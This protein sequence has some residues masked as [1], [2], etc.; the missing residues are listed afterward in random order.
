MYFFFLRN[1]LLVGFVNAVELDGRDVDDY[2]LMLQKG[3]SYVF[4]V[5]H[6]SNTGYELYIS[7]KNNDNYK[8]NYS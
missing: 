2:P 5:S 7:D 8:N 3:Q 4:D 6:E 1:F